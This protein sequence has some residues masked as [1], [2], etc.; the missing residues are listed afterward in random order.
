ME[1]T[2]LSV[3]DAPGVSDLSVVSTRISCFVVLVLVPAI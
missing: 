2:D 3:N 1:R